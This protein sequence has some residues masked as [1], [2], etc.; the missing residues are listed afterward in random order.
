MMD[1]ETRRTPLQR[2]LDG[3]SG[4]ARDL[5]PAAPVT[6]FIY[7]FLEEDRRFSGEA[8]PDYPE[9]G[10]WTGSTTPWIADILTVPPAWSWTP[11]DLAGLAARTVQIKLAEAYIQEHVPSQTCEGPAAVEILEQRYT[12]GMWSPLVFSAAQVEALVSH[13]IKDDAEFARQRLGGANPHVIARYRGSAADLAG[14]I[15]GS[16]GA[17]DP[18]ALVATLTEALARGALFVCDYRPALGGV[19]REGYVR[20]GQHWAVPLVYFVVHAA[21]EPTLLP[22]AIQLD[23]PGG[24]YH[25]TPQDDPNAW[26]LAK[27]WAASSDAQTWFSGTHLFRVHSVGAVFGIAA[28]HQLQQGR[29]SRRHPIVTLMAPHLR[30]VFDINHF[31]YD[32]M[33]YTRGG[34]SFGIYQAGKEGAPSFTDA[35]LPTGRIGVYQIV[36]DLYRDYRFDAAAFDADMAA[37]GVD[38]QSLPV[39]YPYRDDGGLWWEAIRAFVGEIVDATYAD[40]A[41]VEADA[42]LCG[43]MGL[44]EE[45]LN[46]DGTARFSWRPGRAELA[47]ILA[48]ALFL[49]SVQHAAVN[50]SQ[51]DQSGFLP[52]GA[53]AMTAPPPTGPGVT[54]EALLASLPDPRVCTDGACAASVLAQLGVAMAGTA[55][56][57]DVA[58]GDGQ[59]ASLHASYPYPVGSAHH[60]AVS[61]YY[62]ALWT[63]PDSVRARV[64]ANRE[65]RVAAFGAS[66]MP[67][68]VVYPYL[69]VR[70]EPGA[71]VNAPV[72]SCIQV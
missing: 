23:A 51:L 4:L 59:P 72:T 41:A 63:G 56:V 1:R 17:H 46:Q 12:R 61:R 21:P 2:F 39:S 54:D 53:Y 44:V 58:A 33:A 25:F 34:H 60:A 19:A 31:V 40:D 42:E 27:L 5:A 38:A 28:L 6:R 26:L 29:L 47:A 30:K 62:D 35:Y 18:E 20:A 24:G 48:N 14:A 10:L 9:G 45:A 67:N 32:A 22:K 66:P 7:A 57:R 55:P 36:N 13:W 8:Y 11:A 50:D 49:C 64:A 65:A 70:L 3:L 16:A 43:W 71:A 37:R 69:D 52:N 68:S 15:R